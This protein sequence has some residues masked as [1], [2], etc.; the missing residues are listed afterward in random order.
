MPDDILGQM[1]PQ[2]VPMD[3][4]VNQGIQG[5][6]LQFDYKP[7]PQEDYLNKQLQAAL[8]EPPSIKKRLLL[9]KQALEQRVNN[10]NTAL[11]FLEKNPQFEAFQDI[12]RKVL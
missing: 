7:Y 11:E 6:A 9:E 5:S 1:E 8:Y 3:N 2:A 12:L 10:I 4:A